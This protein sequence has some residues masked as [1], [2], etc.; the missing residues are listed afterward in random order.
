MC[1]RL[2]CFLLDRFYVVEVHDFFVKHGL[3]VF[4]EI[5]P[6]RKLRLGESEVAS[7]SHR[8]AFDC[9]AVMSDLALPPTCLPDSAH[10]NK[11]S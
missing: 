1:G 7:L 3:A 2:E 4:V 8:D 11:E 10:R 6:H 5:L 9:P